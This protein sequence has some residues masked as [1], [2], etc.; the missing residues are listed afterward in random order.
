MVWSMGSRRVGTGGGSRSGYSVGSEYSESS[1]NKHW[2]FGRQRWPWVYCS[3]Q[4]KQRPRSRRAV[5]SA[6]VNR[7]IGSLVA[8]E[9]DDDGWGED[10][11]GL[12]WG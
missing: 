8:L 9:S 12:G 4:L 1:I 6:G 10:G 11:N 2:N 3:S 5:I 7:F